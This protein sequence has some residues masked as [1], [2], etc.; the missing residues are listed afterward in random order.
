MSDRTAGGTRPFTFDP[1]T[2]LG[3][4]NIGLD[5][6]G[7]FMRSVEAVLL[8]RGHSADAVAR[9]LAIPL[10]LVRRGEWYGPMSR[11]PAC[12]VRWQTAGIGAGRRQWPRVA[13][14]VGSGQPVVLMP[15]GHHWPGDDHEGREHYHHH[16]VLAHRLDDR[17]LHI[18][19]TDAPAEDGYR[20]VL[21]I[22]DA[23]RKACTRYAVVERIAPPDTRR[24]QEVAA[25]LV[26]RS[27]VPLAE[28]IAELR[29]FHGEVWSGARLPLLLAKGMDVWVLGDVQPQL[30]LLGYALAG[31]EQPHVAEVSRAALAAAGRAQKLGLLL[32]G[33]HRFRSEGVYAMAHE[34]IA[35]LADVLEELLEAMCRHTG[36]LRPHAQGDGTRLVRRLRGETEWCFGEGRPLPELSFV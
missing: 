15:D 14:L 34:E 16:M 32:L 19:D 23:L 6:L 22:T 10:D 12:V 13:E 9:G 29:A 5:G 7:C 35:S 2:A 26:P 25:A 28:D 30:F 3:W 27:L 24:P 4:K 33:L 18:L 1:A 31:A 21:P 20:R 36:T 11:F 8:Q 17:G